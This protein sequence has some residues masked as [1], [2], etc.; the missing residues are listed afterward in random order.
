MSYLEKWGVE[1]RQIME[2]DWWKETTL[3]DVRF[4]SLPAR[5]FSGRGLFDRFKTQWCSWLLIG[6]NNKIFFSGDTGYSDSFKKVGEKFGPIDLT[7][8]KIAA[9]DKLWTD[10][11]LNPEQ[12]VSV[13][14]D[15]RGKV[16]VPIHWSTFN[17]ALHSWYEPI[18]R[19][20]KA[21]KEANIKYLTPRIGEEI[22]VDKH[23]NSSWW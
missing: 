6:K 16:L 9:Y 13:H 5:H 8:I 20:V 15:I 21:G 12:A 4:V 11:H 14:Q 2:L 10:I 3:E 1:K 17:L 23:I 19:L 18:E 22:E 7:F